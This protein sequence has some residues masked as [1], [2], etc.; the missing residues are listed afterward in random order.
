MSLLSSYFETSRAYLIGIQNYDT[1]KGLSTPL[2]DIDDIHECL[3]NHEFDRTNILNVKDAT[4]KDIETV[5]AKMQDEI[6]FRDRVLFYFAGHG[7]AHDSGDEPKGFIIPKDGSRNDET[8]FI[9]MNWL[10][11]KFSRLRCKHFLLIL[12]CCFAG[13]FRWADNYRDAGLDQTKKLYRQKFERFVSDDTVAFQ[14]IT[15]SSYDEEAID[16]LLNLGARENEIINIR[17]SP[18]ASII[19][20]ALKGTTD[21]YFQDGIITTTRLY[22]YIDINIAKYLSDNKIAQ[23]QFPNY[24]P[25]K[26][27]TKGQFIFLVP[28]NADTAIINLPQLENKNPY[29]G[30]ASF[31]STDSHLFFGRKRVIGN[32]IDL[33]SKVKANEIILVSGSSGIGKSSLVMAGLIPAMLE[34]YPDSL[35][36]IPL[37]PGDIKNKS[38]YVKLCS[39]NIELTTRPFILFIDQFEEMVTICSEKERSI[40]ENFI[41]NNLIRKNCRIVISMRSDFESQLKENSII[42]IGLK[43]RF[44]VPPF[45]RSEIKDI[46]TQPALQSVVQFEADSKEDVEASQFIDR[47]CDEAM[48]SLGSLPLLSFALEQWYKVN[49]EKTANR[50]IL[51]EEYYNGIGGVNGALGTIIDAFMKD[52]RNPEETENLKRLML[53]MVTVQEESFARVKVYD[54]ELDFFKADA[55]TRNQRELLEE[56]IKLR[57]IITNRKA[58]LSSDITEQTYYEP[59]HDAVLTSWK[60]LWEWLNAEKINIPVYQQLGEDTQKW[61]DS[62]HKNSLLWSDSANLSI[63]GQEF[64]DKIEVKNNLVRFR[65]GFASTI[66]YGFRPRI[67]EKPNLFNFEERSFIKK[68]LL[69]ARQNKARLNI[70]YSLIVIACIVA[71]IFAI[72]ANIQKKQ[73]ISEARKNYA[74]LLANNSD[75]QEAVTAFYSLNKADSLYPDNPAILQRAFNL[76]DYGRIGFDFLPTN[77]IPLKDELYNLFFDGNENLILINN[78]NRTFK[79]NLKTGKV[80]DLNKRSDLNF[81][82]KPPGFLQITHYAPEEG[83]IPFNKCDNE[84][85]EIIAPG[86]HQDSKFLM[87]SSNHIRLA[88][89][90]G[91]DGFITGDT[92]ISEA[93]NFSQEIKYASFIKDSS[94]IILVCNDNSIYLADFINKK[95][96]QLI[97]GYRMNN[98][99]HF[100][101]ISNDGTM[102]S[103][104]NSNKITYVWDLK[105]GNPFYSNRKIEENHIFKDDSRFSESGKPGE[106]NIIKYSM[107]KGEREIIIALPDNINDYSLLTARSPAF[108]EFIVYR[109]VPNKNYIINDKD[110]TYRIELPDKQNIDRVVFTN[111]SEDGESIFYTV[112]PDSILSNPLLQKNTVFPDSIISK[113][114]SLK[115]IKSWIHR[116]SAFVSDTI[117]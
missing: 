12:D 43:N 116:P 117:P 16:R 79:V 25:L 55:K 31:Q 111:Y 96:L 87:I 73:A 97:K 8:T 95:V 102:F 109:K 7:I 34:Y 11:Q 66:T 101:A 39:A 114:P 23:R 2:Q 113:Y 103:A 14:V 19:I 30:L 54:Y 77:I 62:K 64:Q 57:I 69:N 81:P 48:Q 37:R 33:F 63:V 99:T 107:K 92:C 46:I 49:L 91:I 3:L 53:R 83:I 28:K 108:D 45:E 44:V 27:T 17:N 88:K 13:S 56:L 94:S 24:F 42:K 78:S 86:L 74:N 65:N 35:K 32:L 110:I 60:Q 15:S 4:K 38:E 6:G 22:N 82:D 47:I 98:T 93:L 41:N 76:F 84:V 80:A 29:K 85:H 59:A 68:S 52:L 89:F 51:K 72:N 50:Y 105:L 58:N 9:D 104:V 71:I 70:L 100:Y 18:F 90:T 75:N 115:K 61:K 112:Y 21:N 106:D 36:V 26:R 67:N 10:S 40:W 20:D 5:L 1:V